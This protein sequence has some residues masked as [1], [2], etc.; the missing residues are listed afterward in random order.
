MKKLNRFIS[1]FLAL[2][3]AVELMPISYARAATESEIPV[4]DYVSET[5]EEAEIIGEIE[6]L[7]EEDTKYFLTDKGTTIMAQYGVPVHFEEDGKWEEF[8]NS[9]SDSEDGADLENKKSKIKIKLS[10]KSNGSKLVSLKEGNYGISW[11]FKNANK[12]DAEI[13]KAESEETDDKTAVK[14]AMSSAIYKGIFNNTDI[15]YIISGNSVKENI[16]LNSADAPTE[17]VYEFKAN[18]LIAEKTED[19]N[20]R[21]YSEDGE[22]EY[23]FAVPVIYDGK[24]KALENFTLTLSGNKNKYTVTLKIDDDWLKAEERVFPVIIDPVVSSQYTP[25]GHWETYTY[26]YKD[27]DENYADANHYYSYEHTNAGIDMTGA[28]MRALFRLYSHPPLTSSDKI[29]RAYLQLHT[30]AEMNYTNWSTHTDFGEDL[31][32]GVYEMTKPWDNSITWNKMWG[33]DSTNGFN[34]EVMDYQTITV[35]GTYR[36]DI[37]RAAKKWYDSDFANDYGVM[38]K[39][40][41]EQVRKVDGEADNNQVYFYSTDYYYNNNKTYPW[42]IIEY[43][44][45]NGL[46]NYYTYET[47]SNGAGTAYVN[48]YTGAVSFTHGDLSY[49]DNFGTVSISHTYNSSLKANN[50]VAGSGW[51]VNLFATMKPSTRVSGYYSYIDG[52][53]TEHYFYRPD[54]NKD[55]WK[56]EDGLGMTYTSSDSK[57]RFQDGSYA[58]FNALGNL[59]KIVDAAGHIISIDKVGT[60]TTVKLDDLTV[61]TI[62][63]SVGQISTIT[64]KYGRTTKYSYYQGNL[65]AIEYP[66]GT[67]SNF[68]YTDIH[69]GAK[70]CIDGDHSKCK[71]LLTHISAPGASKKQI[72]RIGYDWVEGAFR[73]NSLVSTAENTSEEHGISNI[74]YSYNQ[75]KVEYTDGSFMVCQ[76]DS[77]GR[78]ACAYDSFGNASSG[79]YVSKNNAAKNSLAS[80][81]GYF[82]PSLNYVKDSTFID[83]G[84]LFYDHCWKE[85]D[86]GITFPNDNPDYTYSAKMT[87]SGGDKYIRTNISAPAGETYTASVYVKTENVEGAGGAGIKIITSSGRTIYSELYKETSSVLSKNGYRRATVTVDLNSGETITSMSIGIFSASGTAYVCGPSLVK[88][89][90]AADPSQNLNGSFEYEVGSWERKGDWIISSEAKSGSKSLEIKGDPKGRYYFYC[91]TRLRGSKGDVFNFGGMAKAAS[92]PALYENNNRTFCVELIFTNKDTGE[93]KSGGTAEFNRVV[94]DWQY[95]AST[96]KAPFDY[97]EVRIVVRYEYNCNTAYFDDIF[98]IRGAQ[99]TYTYDENGNLLSSAD[100]AETTSQFKYNDKG[101]LKNLINPDGS[102]F[103]YTYNDKQQLT[104]ATSNI[105]QKTEIEYDEDTGNP[106]KSTVSSTT[107][108][109]IGQ[110]ITSAV[111][112]DGGRKQTSVTDSRGNTSSTS[113]DSYDRVSSTTS[114]GGTTTSYSYNSYNDRLNSVSV[115]DSST[116]S[117]TYNTDGS[118]NKIQSPTALYKFGYDVLDRIR[119]TKVGNTTLATNSYDEEGRLWWV[120]YGNGDYVSY[121]FGSKNETE[122]VSWNGQKKYS[123]KYDEEGNLIS[124]SGDHSSYSYSYDLIGRLTSFFGKGNHSGGI[125]YD[126]K[127]RVSSTVSLVDNKGFITAYDYD[128]NTGL[129]KK[130]ISTTA[131]ESG[132]NESGIVFSKTNSYDALGRLL[133][134]KYNTTSELTVSYTYVGDSE[135]GTTTTLVASVDIGGKELSYTYDEDGNI[136]EIKENGTLKESYSYDDLGQM[137]RENSVDN[138]QTI[139]YTYDGS[140]NILSKTTYPYTV[141]EITAE[142]TVVTYTYGNENWGDLLTAYNG[143]AITYDKIGNPLKYRSGMKFQ[144]DGGRKLTSFSTPNAA[145]N[146]VYNADGIRV[147]KEVNGNKTEYYLN[148][149]EIQTEITNF[150]GITRRVDYIYD[151][152][153]S[154][155]GFVVDN[156]AKYYYTKN[157]QGDIIGILDSTGTQIVEYSYDAWGKATVSYPNTSGLTDAEKQARYLLG[158]NNPFRYRGYYFDNETGF[159]YLNS[160]YYDPETG[161]FLNADSVTDGGAGVIGNNLFIYAANNPVNNMDPSGNWIIKNAIKWVAKN[162]VKPVVSFVRETISKL[163]TT[164]TKGVSANAVGGVGVSGSIGVTTDTKGNIGIII[165]TSAVTGSPSAG[166]SLFENVTNAPDIYKQRELS[167]AIGGSVNTVIGPS[168]GAEYN[169]FQDAIT[170]DNYSGITASVGLGVSIPPEF[171]ISA[172]YSW[173]YGFNVYDIL[174]ELYIKIMEW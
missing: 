26:E 121:N 106:K 44:N 72:I 20:I 143:E 142:G 94:N 92:V 41:N 50:S 171:H 60:T 5:V 35:D 4:A 145:G 158:S 95:T 125:K 29:V 110:I 47:A 147:Y 57:I 77:Y 119:T 140:G 138:S 48:H 162:V 129:L 73:A 6:T 137:T 33:T 130:V 127:N 99:N 114:A 2:I 31:K 135:Q 161:R 103:T 141:G 39:L 58:E 61:A 116:V 146:Y 71:S 118:L 87:S 45:T 19:G 81:S 134:S 27:E 124:V 153:G 56:D 75:T 163:D 104:S 9:L 157:L 126:N 34:P 67:K 107:D 59:T 149:T 109:S 152:N 63:Y 172:S 51:S 43:R 16:I 131:T 97:K 30:I 62:S 22:F 21:F 66:D 3:M 151:E 24:L 128:E 11:N 100:A 156:T 174:N 122:S 36:F 101:S 23:I 112:G 105:G 165:T 155:Y 86:S 68:T 113:Y 65:T 164:Q 96:I 89:E 13:V 93:N 80:S 78:T 120:D 28:R 70:A 74:E 133:N 79:S 170:G 8:D 55:E 49:S 53:G 38:F 69:T 17:Y 14:N 144:W 42:A 90:Y 117:Y 159:Y 10:K 123:Y 76:F 111:Y 32:I 132:I 82:S 25:E 173:V 154:I 148:G 15:E 115:E 54:E 169:A 108:S 166:V 12:V 88:G 84:T 102:E 136:T 18:G 83:C 98:V 37:T 64:D 7:R 150:G 168:I 160:R 46:E 1:F 167:A 91:D 40:V 85:S 139:L 52:D